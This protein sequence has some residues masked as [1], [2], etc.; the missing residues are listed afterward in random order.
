MASLEST[1]PYFSARGLADGVRLSTPIMP[2][3]AIFGATFGAIAAQKNLSMFDATLMSALVFAGASQFV[4]I[5]IWTHPMTIPVILT[6]A[7]V[8]V[9]VNMRFILM[10]AS[11]RPWLGDLKGWQVYPSFLLLTD[12]AWLVIARYRAEGGADASILYGSGVVLWV[13]WV[14]TTAL[15]FWLGASIATPARYGLDL[16]FPCFFAVMLVPLWDGWRRAI[17]WIAATGT[18]LV[19]SKLLPGWWFIVTGALAGSFVAS[20]LDDS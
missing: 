12:P 17:P 7:I 10:T 6:L 20:M 18:A 1:A 14:A 11:L 8:T 5:E 2:A 16:V 3:M 9:A 15:G 4:A 13:I 19:V